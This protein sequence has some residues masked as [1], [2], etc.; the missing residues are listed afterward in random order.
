MPLSDLARP[1]GTHIIDNEVIMILRSTNICNADTQ[2]MV[3]NVRCHQGSLKSHEII[4]QIAIDISNRT[5]VFGRIAHVVVLDSDIINIELVHHQ[6]A[7]ASVLR[8]AVWHASD[9]GGY[10]VSARARMERS[11]RN[12]QGTRHGFGSLVVNQKR[13]ATLVGIESAVRVGEVVQIA[14]VFVEQIWGYAPD[15]VDVSKSSNPPFTMMLRAEGDTV[16]DA[17]AEVRVVEVTG[18]E[19]GDIA[20]LKEEVEAVGTEFNEDFVKESV[21]VVVVAVLIVVSPTSFVLVELDLVAG[22]VKFLNG[23]IS[24]ESVD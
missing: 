8:S 23:G 18:V 9:E 13:L 2:C 22:A 11:L 20:L 5:L 14:C 3:S 6:V 7:K 15:V 16:G 12:A 4:A 17:G 21:T 19:L 24:I 10:I 1:K